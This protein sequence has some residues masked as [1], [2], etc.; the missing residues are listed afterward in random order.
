M[1]LSEDAYN[2]SQLVLEEFG[3]PYRKEEIEKKILN[4]EEKYKSLDEQNSQNNQERYSLDYEKKFNNIKDDE[5]KQKELEQIMKGNPYLQAMGCSHDRR[6]ERELFEK[7]TK[8]KLD[9]AEYFKSE[10]NKAIKEKDYEKAAYY[11]QKALLQFDYT[12]PDNNEEQQRFDL[13]SQQCFV[14]MSLVK[15]YQKEYDESLQN[16]RQALKLNQNNIKALF[17]IATIH[18]ERD[19]Y[20]K[21]EEV[22]KQMEEI[23][24]NKE[25]QQLK[26]Q[27]VLQKSKYQRDEK[28]VYAD[29]FCKLNK[30]NQE[31]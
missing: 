6:K 5:D 22:I 21:T 4:I 16:A 19:E 23:D 10:G 11:Y 8:E 17:R 15:Y 28:K 18:L 9:N 25:V 3:A 1:E 29:M 12:F 7:P 13:L 20:N 30:E 14:N 24:N 27:L 26:S 2:F 31:K